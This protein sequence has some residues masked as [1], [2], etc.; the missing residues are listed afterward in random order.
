[1]C[2]V[3]GRAFGE[4]ATP[5]FACM[6]VRP[7]WGSGKNPKSEDLRSRVPA[8]PEFSFPR[9]NPWR[10]EDTARNIRIIR[11]HYH[12]VSW[13]FQRAPDEVPL[14]DTDWENPDLLSVI[15]MREPISRIL[16]FDSFTA[17]DFPGVKSA[18]ATKEQ[19]LRY[20]EYDRNTN[21]Y[22]LRILAGDGCCKWENTDRKH[23]ETAKSLLHRISIILDVKCLSEGMAALA[24]LLGIPIKGELLEP[25]RRHLPV[26]DRIPYEEA[27]QK[28]RDR[29]K[30]D[31]E[32]YEYSRELQ[33]IDCSALP[34]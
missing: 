15:V 3:I 29:N 1:M 5:P 14:S 31:I 33:L 2:N 16:A 4:N 28:L 23:L 11:P 13:E 34:D 24:D 20:A 22:A 9:G 6:Q 8:Y 27:Y 18:N 17:R 10:H 7:V 25:P 32:L 19:W 26:R 12:Y 21:N 30:L